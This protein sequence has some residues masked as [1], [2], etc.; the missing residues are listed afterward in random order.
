MTGRDVF[1][2][3]LFGTFVALGAAFAGAF[4][5]FD[6][7]F[8]GV[9][10]VAVALGVYDGSAATE[11]SALLFFGGTTPLAASVDARGAPGTEDSVD[12]SS[13]A[14]AAAIFLDLARM[15]G[16]V[17]VFDAA[18][19]DGTAGTAGDV[20]VVVITIVVPVLG[21]VGC[22]GAGATGASAVGASFRDPC[23]IAACTGC[24][25]PTDGAFA[26]CDIPD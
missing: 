20:F 26:V 5:A 4:P 1:V 25:A 14:A 12:A 9:G 18:G 8:D 3:A 11:F 16:F 19:T 7:I 17:P 10:A 6:A 2:L 22:G 21:S 24:F 13:T 15:V 23:S